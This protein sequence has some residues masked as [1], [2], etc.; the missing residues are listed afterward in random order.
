MCMCCLC[1]VAKYR[2]KQL[3][4]VRFTLCLTED[5]DNKDTNQN[6]N[7][8]TDK[9]TKKKSS[10]YSKIGSGQFM[11]SSCRKTF[12]NSS[13]IGCLSRCG[14]V[15]CFKCLISF[16]VKDGIC[17]ECGAD[18]ETTDVITLQSGGMCERARI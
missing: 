8:K 1:D 12:T 18:C 3:R 11:C 5:D 7:K 16:V 9:D 13:K 14:H 2:L 10:K 6:P 17:S 15:F 4:V